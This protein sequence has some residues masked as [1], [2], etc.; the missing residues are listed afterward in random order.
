MP[1]LVHD[2]SAMLDAAVRLLAATGSA[3]GITVAGVIREAGVSSGSVYHRFPT[4]AALLAAV[5]NRAAESFHAELYDLFSG[6]PVAAAATLGSRTVSWCRAQPENARVLLAGLGSFEPASWPEESRTR[7]EAEQARW[8]EHVR[9]L[10]TGLKRVTGR[11]TAEILLVAV[12]LP[13]AAVRRYLSAGREIPASLDGIVE[14]LIRSQL[15]P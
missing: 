6:E 10:V 14:H 4:R 5:W 2:T 9:G 11:S 13:Y 3:D 1:R 8:D 15:T 7:R 12:D